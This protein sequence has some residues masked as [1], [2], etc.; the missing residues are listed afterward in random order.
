[1]SGAP[2]CSVFARWRTGVVSVAGGRAGMSPLTLRR[3]KVP[4]ACSS[5]NEPLS[6]MAHMR[7]LDDALTWRR[8]PVDE[9]RRRMRFD[10]RAISVRHLSALSRVRRKR[11]GRGLPGCG[12]GVAAPTS[13]KPKRPG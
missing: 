1:M 13:I 4:L 7:S 8:R 3:G 9:S 6:L 5:G 2:Q 10:S 12:R 11:R